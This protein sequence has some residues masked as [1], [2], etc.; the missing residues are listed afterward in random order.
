MTDNTNNVVVYLGDPFA[1]SHEERLLHKLCRDLRSRGLRAVVVAN[2]FTAQPNQRQIDFLVLTDFRLTHI[3]AKALTGRAPLWGGANGPWE[4]VRPGGVVHRI[5]PN[6][7]HQAR[8]GTYAIKDTAAKLIR[9]GRASAVGG[10]FYKHIDTVVC[11]DPAVPA[12]SQL[13]ACT[14]VEVVGYDKL[15]DRL[16]TRGPRPPWTDKDW[17]ELYRHLG[18]YREEEG[19]PAAQRQRNAAEAVDDYAHRLT[20]ALTTG[21]HELVPIAFMSGPPSAVEVLAWLRSGDNVAFRGPSGSGKSH[22]ARHLAVELARRGTLVL[23]LRADEYEKGRFGA[24]LAKAVAPYSVVAATDLAT[25]AATIGR[26][27]CVVVD[28]L[29]ECPDKLRPEL[30]GQLNAFTLRY[31]AT[32]LVTTTPDVTLP[33]DTPWKEVTFQAPA[34]VERSAILASYGAE[35]PETVSTAFTTAFELSVAAK[36]QVSLGPDATPADLFDAYVHQLCPSQTERAGLRYLAAA[37]D[38]ELRTSMRLG[39]ATQLLGARSG[40]CLEPKTVDRVLASALLRVQQGRVS[41]THEQLGRFLAAE[42]LVLAAGSVEQLVAELDKPEHRDLHSLVLGIERDDHR[43]FEVLRSLADPR[44]YMHA[45]E[46]KF[47]AGVAEMTSAA[48]KGALADATLVTTTEGTSFEPKGVFIGQWRARNPWSEVQIAQLEAAGLAVRRGWFTAE[49]A[50]LLDRTDALM[51]AAV[52]ALAPEVAGDPVSAVVAGAYGGFRHDPAHS[53]AASLVVCADPMR[54]GWGAP[55]YPEMQVDVLLAGAGP[56][57]WGRFYLACIGADHE[58][59]AHKAALVDLLT[60]AWEAGGYH[61]R[62]EALQMVVRNG[63]S[64][65][66]GTAW[67]VS[68]VL[69]ELRTNHLFLQSSIVEALAACGAVTPNECADDI[70]RRVDLMLCEPSN[71]D[72]QTVA[73]GLVCSM[74]E[75]VE[76]VGPVCEVIDNLPTGRRVL[77]MAMAASQPDWMFRAWALTQ[78]IKHQQAEAAELDA[79][80][81]I[82]FKSAAAPV[83]SFGLIPQD[84]IATHVL[85]VRGLARA[86]GRPPCHRATGS[87]RE[88]AWAL[89]DGIIAGLDGAVVDTDNAWNEL[90]ERGPGGAVEALWELAESSFSDDLH[91]HDQLVSRYPSEFRRM[92]EWGLAHGGALPEPLWPRPVS[93]ILRYAVKVLGKV[94]NEVTAQLLAAFRHDEDLGEHAVQALRELNSR[95]P[96]A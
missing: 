78:V 21:L 15:L 87:A 3:E 88:A 66:P 35:T 55:A 56:R 43:R 9:S 10:E 33:A 80:S 62:L 17:Q 75:E 95:L 11:I 47:G 4:Q 54:V 52:Q 14:H 8:S 6:P 51:L 1:S 69:Q 16:G 67:E 79:F 96:S 12:S 74:F 2:F 29:N 28:G 60:R 65:D 40:A 77:L 92:L 18:V 89:L 19:S 76:L 57:S 38:S 91:T 63:R 73:V 42:N 45:L 5:E 34:G 59:P 20:F 71:P 22:T 83:T 64:L 82:L 23:W 81:V 27:V 44:L 37:L 90:Y 93:E 39:K 85:G 32:V 46:G 13:E 26:E 61:L 94:G 58:A 30:L 48:V 7:Y 36:C 53:L 70:A 49:V 41:F 31:P 24:L 68:S 25:D 86:T 72:Y 50:A 84:A